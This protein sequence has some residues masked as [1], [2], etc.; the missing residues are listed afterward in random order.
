MTHNVQTARLNQTV[1]SIGNKRKAIRSMTTEQFIK[2]LDQT[3][4]LSTMDN[5]KEK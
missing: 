4:N 3:F 5:I 2:W 1:W